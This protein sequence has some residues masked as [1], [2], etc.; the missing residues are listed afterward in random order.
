M[1]IAHYLPSQLNSSQLYAAHSISLKTAIASLLAK[2]VGQRVM[3]LNVPPPSRASPLPQGNTFA[4][5]QVGR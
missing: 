5:K 1:F 4:E 2:A 3:P